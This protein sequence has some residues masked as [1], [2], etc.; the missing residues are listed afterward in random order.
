MKIKTEI[1]KDWANVGLLS[2]WSPT[3]FLACAGPVL[4]GIRL[5]NVRHIEGYCPFLELYPLWKSN[6]DECMDHPYL[7]KALTTRKGLQFDI[8]YSK[9]SKMFVEAV[10]QCKEEWPMLFNQNISYH[11]LI[12]FLKEYRHYCSSISEIMEIQVIEIIMGMMS[13]MNDDRNISEFMADVGKT[14]SAWDKE[15]IAYWRG[16]NSEWMESLSNMFNHRNM[17]L[18]QINQNKEDKRIRNL[19][20]INVVNTARMIMSTQSCLVKFFRKFTK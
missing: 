4:I 15:K 11:D 18:L 1:T 17:L 16:S 13:F 20:E 3:T 10:C 5:W 12:H 19:N 14:C 2:K 9:H 7:L 6:V 8:P